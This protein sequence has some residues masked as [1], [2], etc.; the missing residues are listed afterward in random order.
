MTQLR[1]SALYAPTFD[2]KLSRLQS[3]DFEDP[4]FPVRLLLKDLN[5]A[6]GLAEEV[7]LHTGALEG[8][9]T[10]VEAA[11]EQGKGESDYSAVGAV[12]DPHRG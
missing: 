6:H 4:N 3:R 5:L 9:C 8:L 7:G 2:A 10:L 11:V 1:Q 12:I